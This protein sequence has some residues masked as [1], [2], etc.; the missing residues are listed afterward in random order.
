VFI[1]SWCGMRGIVSLAAA[2]ALPL[3]TFEGEGFPFRDLLVFLTFLVIFATLVGQGLTLAPLIRRLGLASEAGLH[4][5]RLR[6]RAEMGRAALAAIERHV[7]EHGV[8][9]AL[10]A[11]VRAEFAERIPRDGPAGPALP[12][13]AE[14]ARQLR[15][16]AIQA[17]RAELIRFWESNQVSDD[18]LHHFEEELDYQESRL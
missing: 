13:E 15:L 8:D 10:A 16:A 4:A 9:P 3:E 12:Q 2:L 11:R 1:V 17:E 5:E 6:A 18:V 7:A 14:A